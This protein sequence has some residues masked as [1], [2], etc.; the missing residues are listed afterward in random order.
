MGSTDHET[1]SAEDRDIKIEDVGTGELSASERPGT[2]ES[3]REGRTDPLSD[4]P[5]GEL[6]EEIG[7]LKP[8][9]LRTLKKAQANDFSFSR[10]LSLV[11]LVVLLLAFLLFGYIFWNFYRS[12]YLPDYTEADRY[13]YVS[14][15][16]AE[17]P[18]TFQTKGGD[19][20]AAAA[21]FVDHKRRED[22]YAVYKDGMVY[23]PVSYVTEELNQ[24]FYY[25]ETASVLLYALPDQ[26]L[27]CEAGDT[28]SQL[29]I[30]DKNGENV[31]YVVADL[32]AQYTDI[33]WEF[34][35]DPNRMFVV[36]DFSS[37]GVAV[38]GETTPKDREIPVR[39]LAGVKSPVLTYLSVGE[40]AQLLQM[41]GS[42]WMKV[43]TEDGYIGYVQERYVSDAEPLTISHGIEEPVYKNLSMGEDH[44]CMLWHQIF[45]EDTGV[46]AL[47]DLLSRA[48]MAN[49]I[50]PT[51]FSLADEKGTI[52]SRASE[53]YVNYAHDHGLFVW[54]MVE[55]IS[56]A[57]DSYEFLRTY[58][59]RKNLIDGMILQCKEYHYDGINVD[60]ESLSADCGP[61]YLEFIRELSVECRK[62]GL[63]LSVDNYVPMSYSAFYDR[64]EQGRIVDY[65][66]VM[67]YDEHWGGSGN[68]G[69]TASLPFVKKGVEDAVRTVFSLEVRT[70]RID[71]VSRSVLLLLDRSAETSSR[72][73]RRR[74]P[75]RPLRRMRMHTIRKSAGTSAVGI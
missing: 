63:F 41:E 13:G 50:C 25:D 74:F 36:S 24:R 9:D 5:S 70:V 69:S 64:A 1:G 23:L 18:L 26:L 33:L 30:I 38:K 2:S 40:S 42:K 19:E 46:D 11:V 58:S 54:A 53:K 68:P 39:T 8:E 57:P 67:C 16:T 71:P 72:C 45:E 10:Y 44:I 32:V 51:V 49:V 52:Q 15:G 35:E 12:R 59:A 55:N 27:K 48:T 60:F 31:P 43:E 29:L 28:A 21:L 20:A 14:L 47:P 37:E 75:A 62:E 65:V 34:H 73:S 17:K 61:H 66:I 4:N 22:Q 7:D 6:F 3:R 56:L